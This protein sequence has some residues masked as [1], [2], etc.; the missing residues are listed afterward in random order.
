MIINNILGKRRKLPSEIKKSI[1]KRKKSIFSKSE[2]SCLT[3]FI[4]KLVFSITQ[5]TLIPL[6][7]FQFP[8]R[9]NLQKYKRLI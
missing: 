6:E 5:N 7:V 4:F 8:R 2:K 3:H 1:T 9:I